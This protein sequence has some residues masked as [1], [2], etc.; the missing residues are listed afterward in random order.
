MP[1][2]N[3]TDPVTLILILIGTG[4][5]VFLSQELKKSYIGMIPL[6]IHLILLIAHVIHLVTLPEQAN[7]DIVKITCFC[8]VA[9]FIFVLATFFA[10]LWVDDM[11]AKKMGKRSLD[12]SLDWFWKSV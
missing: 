7:P 5:L 2:I 6:A 1:L 10:Y 4:L 9:D 3:L 12:N 8:L 11:E